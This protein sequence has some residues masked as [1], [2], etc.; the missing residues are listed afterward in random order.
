[1]N[2]ILYPFMLLAG[3]G[4]VLSIIVHGLALAGITVPGDQLVRSLNGGIFIVWLPAVLVSIQTTKYASQRDFWKVALSGCPN[5]MR[6][7]MYAL[8]IY[9]IINFMHFSANSPKSPRGEGPAV[10]CGFAGHWMIFYGVAFSVLYSAIHAPHLFRPRKCPNGHAGDPTAN[11]CPK[12]G[13]AFPA[14]SAND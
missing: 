10:V 3:I 12:C 13:Y 1:M 2:I 9:A 6:K 14:K 7:T 4:L 8:F 5:W 11:F